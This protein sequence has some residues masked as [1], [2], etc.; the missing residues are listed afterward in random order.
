MDA[1]EKRLK[2][3]KDTTS[4]VLETYKKCKTDEL[5]E[6][7]KEMKVKFDKRKHELDALNASKV[8]SAASAG[9]PPPPPAAPIAGAKVPAA[10][11]PAPPAPAPPAPAPPA[12]VKA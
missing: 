2:Q 3:H 8:S 12:P 10:A 5:E 9:A 6:T 4:T 11:A 7:E 1:E